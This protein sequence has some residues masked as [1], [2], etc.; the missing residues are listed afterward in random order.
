MM[1]VHKEGVRV[2]LFGQDLLDQAVAAV[3]D[4]DECV[5]DIVLHVQL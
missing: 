1:Y 5:S 2:Y 3:E 4:C